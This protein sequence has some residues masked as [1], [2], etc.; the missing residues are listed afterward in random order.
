MKRKRK[1]W[2]RRFEDL[3][4]DVRKEALDRYREFEV[5]DVDWWHWCIENVKEDQKENGVD[6]ENCYFDL[7]HR[8]CEFTG[9]VDVLKFFK[10]QVNELIQAGADVMMIRAV[11]SSC[12][13]SCGIRSNGRNPHRNGISISLEIE[14]PEG[15][16]ETETERHDEI[17]QEFTLSYLRDVSD[18]I[19]KSLDTEYD[20]LTSDEALEECFKSNDYLF[21]R[22]GVMV[23]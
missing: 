4:A 10:S 15:A 16:D 11:L 21:D 22:E 8:G 9:S 13:A 5:E 18:E 23:R 7:Y 6:I 1:P 2:P 19:L 12:Y 20:Y 3:P 14:Y 17:F